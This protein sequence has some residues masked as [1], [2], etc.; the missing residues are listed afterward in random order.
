MTPRKLYR[1]MKRRERL[2]EHLALH[3][4]APRPA[5]HLREQL[6]RPLSRAEIRLVQR[7]V[8]ID[9]SDQRDI[10]KMQSLGDHLRAHQDIDFSDAKFIQCPPVIILAASSRRNPFRLIR[11]SGNNFISV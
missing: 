4:S 8:R 6:K 10:R 5:G 2:H 11:A 9:D 1:R 3:I 7:E